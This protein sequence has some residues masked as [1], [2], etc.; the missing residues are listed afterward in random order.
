[1]QWESEL[2]AQVCRHG[3]SCAVE[4]M[5]MPGE[6]PAMVWMVNDEDDV[7]YSRLVGMGEDCRVFLW[8]SAFWFLNIVEIKGLFP[9]EGGGRKIIDDVAKQSLQITSMLKKPARKWCFS[10][11]KQS[12]I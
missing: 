4:K 11:N 3:S 5:K 1:M 7:H 6:D 10:R 2:G 12:M 8:A 9:E